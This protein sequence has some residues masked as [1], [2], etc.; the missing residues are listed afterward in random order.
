MNDTDYSPMTANEAGDI[1]DDSYDPVKARLV[2]P[3]S[4][5][6][7]SSRIP[8]AIAKAEKLDFVGDLY[9]QVWGNKHLTTTEVALAKALWTMCLRTAG[10]EGYVWDE[11]KEALIAFTEKVESLQA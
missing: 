8:A 1:E 7:W 6:P 4:K 10:T 5:P 11:F 9:E 2:S 3:Q